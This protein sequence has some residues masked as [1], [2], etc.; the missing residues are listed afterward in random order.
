[1]FSI[2]NIISRADELTIQEIIGKQLIKLTQLLDEKY[3]KTANLKNIVFQIY[4]ERSFLDNKNLRIILIN[5]LR[6]N[7]AKLIADTLGF[8]S[9]SETDEYIFLKK[10]KLVNGSEDEMIFY[11][12]FGIPI[13][14]SDFG[15][16]ELN[17]PWETVS[18]DYQLF[19]H[20]RKAVNDLKMKLK[21]YPHRVLLHMPTGSGKTRTT[22][23]LLA[24]FLREN[25][26]ALIIWLASTEELCSQSYLEFQRAW[27]YLGNRSLDIGKLWGNN[28]VEAIRHINDGLIVA[29]FQ[30][31]THYLNSIEGLK[32]LSN[33]SSKFSFIVVDEA[34]QSIAE[35]YQSVIEI[36]YNSNPNTR[37][38][39]L[40]A[41][42]GRTWNDVEEDRKL[43]HFYNQQKVTL[44]ISNYQNPVDYLIKNEYIAKVNYKNLVYS[45]E[46]E[47][48]EQI[49]RFQFDQKKDYS[50][51]ILSL[52]GSDA[53]RNIEI[54]Y[55]IIHLTEKHKRIIVFA[56]SVES[57]DTIASILKLKG[58]FAYSVT[59]NTDLLQRRT[60]IKEFKDNDD[61]VKIIC[62][63]G[64]LTTGF[65]SPYTSA[66]VIARP[67]LSL[68][69]YSQMIGRAIRGKK[70]GGNS[71]AEV[72]TVVDTE[73][74][75][76]K[77]VAD[78][79]YNWE[80]V[81]NEYC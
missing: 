63:Y 14:K 57:S 34:H 77:S 66:A 11:N 53:K 55:E 80:D 46:G 44:Q 54:I 79:F 37:L 52:L 42:P 68:V 13:S 75:G 61:T 5:L 4:E 50:K 16:K 1:M 2:K 17:L 35:R 41:T 26:P 47:L 48:T 69:L 33:I 20:Q 60:I 58:L 73:L 24:D 38:L 78:S 25:E 71:E 12:F 76:F 29:G 72:V 32:L 3:L 8:P 49:N 36:I 18:A 40:S 81:W 30:K 22:M 70:A 6:F 64:V 39:G 19:P 67:T 27:S 59:S 28:D 9:S 45:N 23:S 43:A 62:N 74:P 10:K 56:P 65:D 51:E 31:L 21:M 15:E 7:E